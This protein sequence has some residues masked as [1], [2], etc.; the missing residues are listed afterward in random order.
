M[1]KLLS[2]I[3][4]ISFFWEGSLWFWEGTSKIKVLVM[5]LLVGVSCKETNKN[6]SEIE[7]GNHLV[8]ETSPYLLQHAHNPVDWYPWGDEALQLAKDEEKLLVISI[9]YS[10]C[11]WCH[12]M[13]EES[14]SNNSVAQV[15]NED[16]INIKVDREE[17]P[18]VDHVYMTAAQMMNGSGGWP[19][20]VIALP[21]GRPVFISSY[22]EKEAWMRVLAKFQN[23]FKTEPEKLIDYANQVAEGLTEMTLVESVSKYDEFSS[24]ALQEAITEWKNNWDTEWG[25]DRAAEKFMLPVRLQFLLKYGVMFNDEETKAHVFNTLHKMGLSG[26]YDHIGGGFFRYTTDSKWQVPHFEKMLYDNAQMIGLYADAFKVKKDSKYKEIVYNTFRFLEQV[27]ANGKG[28]YYAAI[29]AD[30]DGREG[31]YYLWGDAELKAILGKDFKDFNT[32]FNAQNIQL[33]E[34]EAYIL[35]PLET[36]E[37]LAE[38][39]NMDFKTFTAKKA[40]WKAKLFEKRKVRKLP[41]IDKKIICSWNAQLGSGYLE[42]Y[43]AFGDQ[44]FLDKAVEIQNFITENLQDEN[45]LYHSYID[46]KLGNKGFL[47]DYAYY[48]DFL[49]NMYSATTKLE[50]L[51]EAQKWQKQA[52][53]L[54]FDIEKRVYHFT[55]ETDLIAPVIKL[56]DGVQPAPNSVM[57][58]NVMRLG[59]IYFD[60]DLKA[61]AKQMIATVQPDILEY[62]PF[63]SGWAS[64]LLDLADVA[65]EVAIVG[66][67]ATSMLNQMNAAYLPNTLIVASKMESTIPVFQNR[68]SETQTFIYICQENM[69]KLPLANVTSAIKL[70]EEDYEKKK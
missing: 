6:P 7:K 35:Q 55:S 31:R 10:T 23:Y 67:E 9:G 37:V 2:S 70:I 13:E 40:D 57:A 38:R 69:C 48:M 34:A 8:A 19:L 65:Y 4:I 18:D 64:Q 24:E 28:G 12:V 58:H 52:D 59:H 25:G 42:A 26:V 44:V 43:M 33:P 45:Q 30:S 5:L 27:M 53:E 60:K 63:Y 15:M 11:H 14:F 49:I 3:S 29:D 1:R 16:F 68:F 61:K 62:T 22:M 47:E 66:P 46:G 50:Y 56:D 17:R 39:L 54:F 20:N 51:E 32:V 36:D 21:D 41:L